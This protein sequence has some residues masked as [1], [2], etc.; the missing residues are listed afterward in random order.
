[1]SI[2]IEDN[3]RHLLLKHIVMLIYKSIWC[4]SYNVQ[5]H[6]THARNMT[7]VFSLS[8]FAVAALFVAQLLVNW[9][10]TSFH[11]LLS[12]LSTRLLIRSLFS[13]TRKKGISLEGGRGNKK[14]KR[15]GSTKLLILFFSIKFHSFSSSSDTSH[16]FFYCCC[17]RF[18]IRFVRLLQPVLSNLQT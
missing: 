2:W 16:I 1:M 7:A 5:W 18:D 10:A 17:H 9:V 13:V 14:R 15:K 11:F 12:I 6:K 3:W 8:L 4:I